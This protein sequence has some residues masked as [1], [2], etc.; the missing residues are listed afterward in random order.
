MD[1]SSAGDGGGEWPGQ[2]TAVK[3]GGEA[4]EIQ[5]VSVDMVRINGYR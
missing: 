1:G 3:A 5:Q 2:R 4:E